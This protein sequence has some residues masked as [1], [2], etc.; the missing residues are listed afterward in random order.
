MPLRSNAPSPIEDLIL[1]E[2]KLPAS[3][4]PR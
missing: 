4:M 3:V 1:P 2:I